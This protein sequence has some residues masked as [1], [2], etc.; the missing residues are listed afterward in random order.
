[1]CVSIESNNVKYDK[2]LKNTGVIPSTKVKL[3]N[4]KVI[5]II[6]VRLGDVL[7]GGNQVYG[8][9]LHSVKLF[10][11][12]TSIAPNVLVG[13]GSW[14]LKDDTLHVADS[15]GHE[16]IND[17]TQPESLIQL[18]TA[19]SMFDVYDLFGNKY[20]ILDELQTTEN[21]YHSMKDA[22][23]LDGSFRGKEIRV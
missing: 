11:T 9:V 14:V 23:I 5:P 17:P 6:D 21:F 10:D 1:M 2:F 12:I 4:G 19:N 13:R 7:E 16:T 15:I 20:T 8:I 3:D 22:M 18:I